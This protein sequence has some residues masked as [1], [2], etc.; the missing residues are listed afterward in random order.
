MLAFTSA[1]QEDLI[2]CYQRYE[3]HQVVHKLHN[4]CSEDLGGFYLDI[5]K[6]RLYTSATGGLPRRSAQ[7]VLYHIAHGL[8]RLFAPILSFTADEAWEHFTGETDSSVLLQT[9]HV[10][11]A[12]PEAESQQ[13]RWARIRELRSQVLKKL[14]ES[15]TQGDIGSSLAAKVDIHVHAEDF[16]ILNSLY[17]DLRFVLIVSEVNLIRIPEEEA[18]SISVQPS[19]HSKCE[20][21]WHYREDV[22]QHAEHTTLCQRCISNL[23]GQG[24]QRHYA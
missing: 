7:T 19:V 4:Y 13:Q 3:F 21:C 15:R 14:E 22:G 24:E 20:R 23:F 10:F 9:W 5:L 16:A 17:D 2:Q 11:P 12:Q 8:V 18:E 6:D 1:I